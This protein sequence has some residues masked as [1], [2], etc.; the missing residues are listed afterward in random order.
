LFGVQYAG[1]I[2]G[3]MQNSYLNLEKD[4]RTGAFHPLLKGLEDAGRIINGVRRVLVEPTSPVDHNPLTLIPS[5]PDLPMEMVWVRVPHTDI[6]G[7]FLRE[8]G[9]GQVVYFPWD[10]DRTFWEVLCLDHG[11]LL[12]NAVNWLAGRRPPVEVFGPGVLDVTV[13]TQKQSMTVHLVNL[14][15]P[16]MMKGPVRELLPVGEQLVRVRLPEGRVVQRVRL[17]RSGLS[18]QVTYEDGY[19]VTRV[20]TVLDHEVLAVD[21]A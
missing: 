8:F 12:Q 11:K 6:P 3:P 13:W 10:I 14:T 21:F 16:M 7:V 9:E 2:E 1:G 4:S 18:P 5:Y 15:N 17:L 20:P 19:L